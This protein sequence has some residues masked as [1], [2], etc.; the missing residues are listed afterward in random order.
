[1]MTDGMAD[2]LEAAGE[3]D[4][5]IEELLYHYLDK[6]VAG[7][8]QGIADALMEEAVYLSGGQVGDDM[9]ILVTEIQE[10]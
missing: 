10:R 8:P 4:E 6:G 2:C 9:S 7:D 5:D 3:F 1:M